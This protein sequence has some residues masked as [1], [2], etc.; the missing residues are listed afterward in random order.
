MFLFSKQNLKFICIIFILLIFLAYITNINSIPDNIILFEDVK[1]KIQ[2]MIGL[3]II[4]ND[5]TV[6]ASS[7][8]GNRVKVNENIKNNLITQKEYNISLLGINLKTIKTDVLKNR[9]VIPLGDIVGI[10][11]Y[12]EGVLVVGLKEVIGEDKQKYKPFENSEIEIGDSI[13]KIDGIIVNSTEE[14]LECLNKSKG[15]KISITYKKNQEEKQTEIVPVKTGNGTYKLGLWVRD[16]AAGIGT[17]TFYDELTNS[18]VSLGH[19]IQDIDTGEMVDISYGEFT[20]TQI[21]NIQKGEKQNPGRIEGSID[22]YKNIGKIYNNSQ[23]GVF[24]HV[25]SKKDFKIDYDKEMNIALRNE[26][27]EGK[28]QILCTLEDGKISEYEINIQKVFKNN[29]KNNKSMIIKVTDKKLLEK[30][31]GIIQGMSGSPIIQNGKF[32]GALTHVLVSDPTTGYGVFADLM[33]KNL[34]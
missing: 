28:A 25:I 5:Q 8:Y 16:A 13:T 10:K 32:I 20:T 33:I 6:E 34:E 12:T 2:K 27:K 24:G 21:D 9:K 26:I 30:S 1:P 17:L 3:N 31:G 11:L 7:K 23:F 22:E 19:G 15:K 18:I 14:L 29:S 4:E